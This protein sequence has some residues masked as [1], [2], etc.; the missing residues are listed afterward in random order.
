MCV[1]ILSETCCCKLDA[2]NIHSYVM[3]GS[4][5]GWWCYGLSLVGVLV[6]VVC[7]VSL[8]VGSTALVQ[9]VINLCY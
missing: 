3:V 1:N 6:E 2:Y 7:G 9:V 5:L 4:G 8:S